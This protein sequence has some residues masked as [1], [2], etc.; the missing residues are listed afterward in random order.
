M[1]NISNIY[2]IFLINNSENKTVFLLSEM[3]SI[4]H[5]KLF[6]FQLNGVD[7]RLDLRSFVLGDG[8]RND[9]TGHAAG[10]TQSLLG[11]ER[12]HFY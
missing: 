10:T 12:K 6:N 2:T 4:S 3:P 11:T 7:L 8:S 1:I 9:R 5:Q